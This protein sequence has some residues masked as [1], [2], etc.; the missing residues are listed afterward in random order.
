MFNSYNKT[1]IILRGSSGSGKSSFA[2]FLSKRLCG[3]V[4]NHEADDFFML[5]DKYIFNA[6]DLPHAHFACLSQTEFDMKD[7]VGTIIISN[8][9]TRESEIQPYLDL[10]AKYNYQVVSLVVENRHGGTSQ[11]SVPVDT[12]KKQ[13]ER[14]MQSIK[15]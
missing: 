15:L 1:L 4:S 12:I 6:K 13:K 11:H 9:S 2:N 8:T 14:L 7:N 10:A 3:I 5:E